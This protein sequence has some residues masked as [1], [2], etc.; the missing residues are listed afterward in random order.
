MMFLNSKITAHFLFYL[1]LFFQKPYI[2]SWSEIKS[3]RLEIGITYIRLK[4]YELKSFR[5]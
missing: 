3:L 2:P 1:P 4:H 5:Y